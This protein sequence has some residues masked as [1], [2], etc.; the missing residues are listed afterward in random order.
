M[1]DAA[2]LQRHVH[3]FELIEKGVPVNPLPWAQLQN[4]NTVFLYV[5]RRTLYVIFDKPVAAAWT[6]A[7]STL[8]VLPPMVVGEAVATSTVVPAANALEWRSLI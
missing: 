4:S 1:L 7:F 5:P 6:V 3:D 8:F 2:D